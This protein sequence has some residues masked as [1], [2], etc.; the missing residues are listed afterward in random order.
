[1]VVLRGGE[2]KEM[3]ITIG[4][5]KDRAERVPAERPEPSAPSR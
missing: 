2:Q 5:Y 1:M 3:E 4:R